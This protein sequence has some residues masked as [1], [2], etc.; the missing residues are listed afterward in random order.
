[1][2]KQSSKGFAAGE[3]SVVYIDVDNVQ[4]CWQNMSVSNP[5][6]SPVEKKSQRLSF[7]CRDPD[8]R[9]VEVFQR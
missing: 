8:G 4:V 2:L 3:G 1:M 7:V 6:V 9:T 5:H